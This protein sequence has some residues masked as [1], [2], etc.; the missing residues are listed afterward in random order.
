MWCNYKI[1][2]KLYCFQFILSILVVLILV[3]K[4]LDNQDLLKIFQVTE[5][6]L[7]KD[8]LIKIVNK[9]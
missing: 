8:Q 4:Q 5:A 3:T 1:K 7:S 2:N 6:K 9:K